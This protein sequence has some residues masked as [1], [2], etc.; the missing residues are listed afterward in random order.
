MKLKNIMIFSLLIPIF[1]ILPS[2]E[3]T[4]NVVAQVESI[5]RTEETK[6]ATEQN[7]E[8]QADMQIEI[9]GQVLK[10]QLED[11]T[12]S[13][14]LLDLLED[15]PLTISMDDYGNMEKVGSLGETLP[16]NDRQITT[17][18]GDVILYQGHQLAIYHRPN[19]WNFTKLGQVQYLNTSQ[20]REA[21]G[22]G[23]V[24]ATLSLKD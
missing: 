13:Q 8:E 11:N 23:E 9:N 16:R 6:K 2:F 4:N 10:I 5:T 3:M 18:P 1:S 24:N 12:S 15:G 14:A 7:E 20:L 19:T 21:L 22:Q 17:Q